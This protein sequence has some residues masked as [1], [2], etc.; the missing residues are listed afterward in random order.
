[1]VRVSAVLLKT[2]AARNF[3]SSVAPGVDAHE[4][5]RAFGSGVFEFHAP[6]RGEDIDCKSQIKMKFLSV[7]G[8]ERPR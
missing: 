1:M 7:A 4:Y 5:H 3:L 8:A 2:A 6:P